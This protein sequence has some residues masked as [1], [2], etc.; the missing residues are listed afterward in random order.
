MSALPVL[1]VE[2]ADDIGVVSALLA[3]HG[4]DTKKGAQHLKIISQNS[5]EDLLVNMPDAIKSATGTPV[6]F[7]LDIDI[8]LSSRWQAVRERLDTVGIVCNNECPISGF[9]SR[10]PGYPKPCGVWLMPDCKTDFQKMEDL[11]R[12]LVP[13]DHPVWPHVESSVAAAASLIDT[14]NIT[15]GDESSRWDRFRDV[16]KIKSE[17]NTWLSW[18]ARP[19]CPL[20]TAINAKILS[21]DSVQAKDFLRWMGSLYGFEQLTSI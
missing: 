21:S 10:K 18:Q 8:S 13:P 11:C 1:Y 9:I 19:G 17:I 20:G 7:V 16:D 15:I 14:I 6:G 12:T 3:R 2:G 5:V 4:I